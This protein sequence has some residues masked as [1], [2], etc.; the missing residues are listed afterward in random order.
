MNRHLRIATVLLVGLVT[1]LLSATAILAAEPAKGDAGATPAPAAQHRVYSHLLEPREHPDYDRR[2]VKPP[3]WETFGNRTQFIALRGFTVKDPDKTIVDFEKELELY[4]RT[5]ELGDVVWPFYSIMF[6][7]NLGELADAIKRRN[8]YL[9]DIW[10]YVPGS[11]PGGDWQQFKAQP[12][13]FAMLESKLG[14]RWLGMDNGEQ[15]GR[16]IG[17]YANQMVPGSVDRLEQYFNFQRHF[18]RLGDD[19]GQKLSTLVSLNFGHYF[20]KEGTYTMIGAETAQALPNSQVYYAF[21]RGAGK[22]YGVPWFGN[23]SVWNRWGWKAY[24]SSGPDFGP[25]KGT[26]VSLLK[27]LL[28]CHILYN[29]VAVGFESGCPRRDRHCRYRDGVETTIRSGNRGG[30]RR[31]CA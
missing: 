23:A 17:G 19:L 11:G 12:E 26:S 4:T 20:L 5:H 24:G 25:T 28:Y 15:D 16:Y 14:E 13:T 9:F 1:C 3:T 30:E 29:A 21:I 8:L 27:R 2:A 6:A 10:G 22:Q 18:E 31:A 7:K